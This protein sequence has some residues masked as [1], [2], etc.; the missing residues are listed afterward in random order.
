MSATIFG[1]TAGMVQSVADDLKPTHLELLEQAI[2]GNDYQ[3][4]SN[5]LDNGLDINA[6]IEGDGTLLIMAIQAG[7]EAMVYGL[8]DAGA[9][10]NQAVIADGNPLI[11]AAM[12]NN[13]SVAQRLFD[14][15]ALVDAIV[16]HDE[17]ALINAS[18][19][20]HFEM[21]KFLVEN[22]ADVNLGLHV[23]TVKGNI[24]R[25]P[26]NGA[27]TDKIRDYLLNMGAK[28]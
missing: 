9:D 22:G 4:V 19:K 28:S 8:I 10:V 15:G 2:H 24:Y 26:L 25:S 16:E 17:T 1:A 7:H 27:K 18:R 21:V 5:M 11:N 14:E 23:N 13:V 6:V 12:T 3:T 20:G